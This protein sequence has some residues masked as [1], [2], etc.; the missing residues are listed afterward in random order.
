[1]PIDPVTGSI[2]TGV[3][4]AGGTMLSNRSNR[5]EAERNRDFQERMS[6]TAAQRAVADYTA[7][8]LNPALA[9]DKPASSPGGS[10]IPLDNPVE[11]GVSSAMAAKRLSGELELV[12]EQA[13]KTRNER[14]TAEVNARIASNT[15]EENT[16]TAIA[17]ARNQRDLLPAQLESVKIMNRLQ[18][19]EIPGAEAMGAFAKRMGE[20]GPLGRMLVPLLRL[21][22]PR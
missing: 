13:E 8:G 20:L 9:F 14:R 7:A 15:E 19:A 12:R 6:S 21:I 1:M 4:S 5:R 10:V 18:K 16:R 3:L 22:K 11:A 2:I 17:V